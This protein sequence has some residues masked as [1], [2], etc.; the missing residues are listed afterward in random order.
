M[1]HS[2]AKISCRTPEYAD[3]AKAFDNARSIRIWLTHSPDGLLPPGRFDIA[4]N[5][6]PIVSRGVGCSNLPVRINSGPEL[7][8]CELR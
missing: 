3:C 4:G 8:L 2:P 5:G 7:I 1:K 6:P